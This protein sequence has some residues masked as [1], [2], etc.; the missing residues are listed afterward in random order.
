MTWTSTP[1]QAMTRRQ[2]PS[3]FPL[4]P[5]AQTESTHTTKSASYRQNTNLLS[6]QW[7]L[8]CLPADRRMA[9]S[10]SGSPRR[11]E[12]AQT[13]KWSAQIK[14]RTGMALSGATLVNFK[15]KQVCVWGFCHGKLALVKI[16]WLWAYYYCLINKAPN[17]TQIIKIFDPN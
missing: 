16:K 15:V 5:P 13:T 7:S 3:P 14:M 9:C 10:V 11:F 12:R 4:S 1:K 17:M 8:I 2:L 6:N